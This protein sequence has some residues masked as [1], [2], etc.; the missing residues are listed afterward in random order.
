MLKTTPMG[1]QVTDF[2]R[3]GL[4]CGR[5]T[6]QMPGRD[7]LASELGV[8]G[9][10]INRALAQLER[11]GLLEPQGVGK[12][13]RIVAKPQAATNMPV[14]MILYERHDMLS[15]YVLEIRG[16][17]EASGLA[18]GF[19]PKTLVELRQDPRLVAQMVDEHPGR[20]WIVQS[21]SR[22]VL[23]WFAQ[24]Q[25]HAFALFGIMTN[26]PIA[27]TGPELLSPMRQAIARL[28]ET[29]HRRLVMLAREERRKTGPGAFEHTFLDELKKHGFQT[30]PF[31]LPD[32]HESADGLSACLDGLF[33]VTPPTAILIQDWNLLVAV[34][35]YLSRI[36]MP[37]SKRVVL[38]CFDYHPSFNW[39]KPAFP[40]FRW[41]N[42]PIVNHVT[43]WARQAAH[44]KNN[45]QQ[46]LYPARFIGIESI[47]L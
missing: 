19:A 47:N 8:N 32:W 26:L 17:I 22:P 29:G 6:G 33:R 11:E 40:H 45:R 21:G 39:C 13:R 7:R 25:V 23:E 43:R 41:D 46:K 3:H 30:G 14:E 10:M 1:E 15:T 42:R 12:R 4:A 16:R 37:P 20:V 38:I 28:M 44:G 9:G 34:Q 36:R 35:D 5:W 18:F 24:A 31:N 2:L 27:G